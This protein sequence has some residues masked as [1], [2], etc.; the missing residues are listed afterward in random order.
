MNTNIE[1]NTA[2]T[3]EIRRFESYIK[4]DPENPLLWVKIGDLYHQAGRFEDAIACFEKCLIFDDGDMVARGR[5]ANVLISQHRFAEAEN[6][7]RGIIETTGEDAPLMHNLGLTI[8]YQSRFA[9]AHQFFQ[10]ARDAG[11]NTPQ[12]LAYMVYSL[13]HEN[14]T[15]EA[16]ELANTWIEEAPGP[17]TEGYVA[18]LE[19]DHGD[20]EKATQRA[21][22]VFELQP[23]NADA[24][25][26]LGTWHMEHQESTRAQA[27]FEQVVQSE[28]DNTRGWQGLGLV[29]MYQQ[30]LKQAIE[31]FEKAKTLNEKDA[32]IHLLIGWAKL[33]ARD[34]LGAEKAFR[35]AINADHNFGEAHGGLACAL[36]FQN[37]A[38]EARIEIRK[39]KGLDPDSF[40]GTFANA[41]Y[42]QLQGDNTKATSM[43]ADL[44]EKQP[45]PR[46]KPIILHLQEY[47]SNQKRFH[48]K[49]PKM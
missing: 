42:M 8:Y 38:E 11:L 10:K 46:S 18:M 33:S 47:L 32:T 7:I 31:Y 5:L 36:V 15:T 29:S 21:Q 4:A 41:I 6:M 1:A 43:I 34:A 35:A 19:M 20:M 9:E 14:K 2:M 49:T 13:H 39:A 28:P 37:R 27:H 24:N 30:D 22:Q 12:T 3:N 45:V 40:G 25:V 23:D 16:L 48:T 26:V 44:F 17:Q